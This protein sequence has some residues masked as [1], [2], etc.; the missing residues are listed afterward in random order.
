MKKVKIHGIGNQ[1]EFNYLIIKK[2]KNFFEFLEQWI[3]ESFPNKYTIETTTHERSKD[4]KLKKINPK[5]YKDVHETYRDEDLRIDAF[6]GK[7][8]IFLTIY[9]P[10]KN[11]KKLMQKIEKFAEFQN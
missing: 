2:D 3:A 6:F 4:G 10:L 11:R 8:K 1:E 7:T 5:R 9:T